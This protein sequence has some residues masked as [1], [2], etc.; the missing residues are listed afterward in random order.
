[1][2]AAVELSSAATTIIRILFMTTP[3]D[4]DLVG[5]TR[6]VSEWFI[7]V[8]RCVCSEDIWPGAS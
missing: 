3:G 6:A 4:E 8:R 1:M 7:A 5:V 2:Q